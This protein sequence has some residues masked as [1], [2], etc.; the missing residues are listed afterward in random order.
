MAFRAEREKGFHDTDKA[1]GIGGRTALE[2]YGR[3]VVSARVSCYKL[4]LYKHYQKDRTTIGA[5]LCKMVSYEKC[6]T[7]VALVLEP[8]FQG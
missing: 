2:G 3:T 7:I 5:E 1:V 6:C 8:F 4:S